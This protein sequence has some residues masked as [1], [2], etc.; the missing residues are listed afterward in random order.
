MIRNQNKYKAMNFSYYLGSTFCM[1]RYL[2][3]NTALT[4]A[5]TI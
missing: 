4:F 1:P 2:I 5:T 3:S